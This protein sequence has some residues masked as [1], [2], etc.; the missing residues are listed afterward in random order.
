MLAFEVL[1]AQ[2]KFFET[3]SP[4]IYPRIVKQRPPDNL[5][6]GLTYR[7]HV[8]LHKI[9]LRTNL[10][11]WLPTVV[12]VVVATLSVTVQTMY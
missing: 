7:L 6:G 2:C 8:L 11:L 12:L 3:L 10:P 4:M 5:T 9:S 1:P